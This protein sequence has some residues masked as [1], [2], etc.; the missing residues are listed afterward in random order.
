VPDQE[1]LKFPAV[2]AKPYRS[3]V[4]QLVASSN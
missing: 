2:Q 3:W 4:L 1:C